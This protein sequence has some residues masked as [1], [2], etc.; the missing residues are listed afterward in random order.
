MTTDGSKVSTENLGKKYGDKWAVRGVDLAA[1]ELRIVGLIGPSGCGKTTLVRM[2]NGI[3]PPDEGSVSLLGKDPQKFGSTD[4]QR[5]GYLP[6]QAVLFP[7]LSLWENLN[8]HASL[9]GVRFRRRARLHELLEF[10]EL[11]D[12]RKKK[13]H[14]ASGGMQRRLALAAVLVHKPEVLFLDEPTAGIDPILRRRIWERF[15]LLRDEGT[16][17]VVTTQYVGEAAD[18]DDVGVL[19]EGQ[20]LSLTSPGELART[21]YGGDLVEIT[22][23][24]PLPEHLVAEADTLDGV[25]SVER[26]G[27][28]SAQLVVHEAKATLPLLR[29]WLDHHDVT[30]TSVDEPTI[31]FDEVFVRIVE[32]DRGERAETD[33]DAAESDDSKTGEAAEVDLTGGNQQPHERERPLERF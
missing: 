12:D 29:D 1:D 21:A 5:I 15:R 20:L 24:D 30:T 22:S 23:V 9:A 18:C 11:G 8:Y 17:L 6:Q 7:E 2:L 16:L 27:P 33:D 4:R 26:I 10:V 3:L 19:S 31:D 25:T 28:H 32:R 14:E 13:V